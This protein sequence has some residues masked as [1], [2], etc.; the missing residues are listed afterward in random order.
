MRL[1]AKGTSDLARVMRLGAALAVCLCSNAGQAQH[2]D[3]NA[4]RS[5]EDAFGS[6][7]GLQT[8]G[9]YSSDLV[10]GF[11]PQAAGNLR[12]EGL[13]FDQQGLLSERVIE[14]ST[15]RVG[16][17]VSQYAFPAPTGI[18]DYQLRQAGSPGSFTPYI[19]WNSIGS[20]VVQV[21]GQL[22]IHSSTLAVPLGI[23]VGQFA[24]LAGLTLQRK[25]FGMVPRLSFGEC[26]SLALLV[27]V[28]QDRNSKV[29]PTLYLDN[30]AT[31]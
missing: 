15:V 10:R 18:V 25:S 28:A 12:I 3:D 22:P 31:E 29:N 30:A 27:D 4:A 26:G 20:R 24:D 19:E 14:A 13:Y 21:D 16:A 1:G 6:T 17:S 5:A 2:V 11:S 7:V 8:I 9:L 23:Q